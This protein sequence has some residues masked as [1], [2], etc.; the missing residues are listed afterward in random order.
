M[1]SKTS[2]KVQNM[3]RNPNNTYFSI[4]D[5]SFPYKGVKGRAVARISEDISKNTK[6]MEKINLKYLG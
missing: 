3:Q 6:I 4:D 5:E 1:V 2:K